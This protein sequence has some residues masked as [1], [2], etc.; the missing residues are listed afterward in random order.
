MQRF[1]AVYYMLR[2]RHTRS[3]RGWQIMCEVSNKR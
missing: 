3:M 2:F 1:D